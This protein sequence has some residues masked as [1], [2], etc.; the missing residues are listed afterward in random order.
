MNNKNTIL[1]TIITLIGI[2]VIFVLFQKEIQLDCET[3]SHNLFESG[4]N[5]R[6]GIKH[7]SE[8]NYYSYYDNSNFM[9]E[10]STTNDLIEIKNNGAF[11]VPF[12]ENAN[13]NEILPELN[14]SF[15]IDQVQVINAIQPNNYRGMGQSSYS[16]DANSFSQSIRSNKYSIP[17]LKL[18]L[19]RKKNV[20]STISISQ[21]NTTKQH[22]GFYSYNFE[23]SNTTGGSFE[24]NYG[25]QYVIVDPGDPPDGNPIPVPDGTYFLVLQ[26]VFYGIWKKKFQSNDN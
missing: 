24:N 13:Y 12:S 17:L 1:V 10:F 20:S 16:N 19:K 5:I 25:I 9:P 3:S 14:N 18:N 6:G 15:H 23:S 22:Y 4:I 7:V 2:L 11:S 21:E 8:I 26:A